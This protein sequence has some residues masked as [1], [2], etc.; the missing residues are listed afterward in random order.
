MTTWLPTHHNFSCFRSLAFFNQFL[1]GIGWGWIAPT[2]NNLR[3]GYE[4]D[5]VISDEETSWLGSIGEFGRVLGPFVALLCL[6]RVGRK[7]TMTLVSIMYILCW[8]VTIFTRDINILLATR[9]LFGIGNGICGVG[10]PIYI[11]EVCSPTYRGF[12]GTGMVFSFFAGIILA[13]SL[14]AYLSFTSAAIVYTAL[15]VCGISSQ[16]LGVEPPYFLTMKGRHERARKNLA[17]LRATPDV[18][19]ELTKIEENVEEEKQKT[20]SFVTL[21]TNK[22]NVRA[23]IVTVSFYFLF[24]SAGFH[25]V[26]PYGSLIF[27][28]SEVFTSNDYTP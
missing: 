23:I 13:N 14:S 21:F 12:G 17:W 20:E 5:L 2:L 25:A 9:V 11:A 4:P 16:F 1:D 19:D 18:E 15:T 26:T 8:A 22:T 3:S 24:S 27:V 6:D 28:P 7:T 10:G